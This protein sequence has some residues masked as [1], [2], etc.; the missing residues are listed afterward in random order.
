MTA[1]KIYILTIMLCAVGQPQCVMPQAI[2]EHRT[3]YD[4]VK[5]VKFYGSDG[6]KLMLN[7][8]FIWK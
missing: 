3:H 8:S 5:K 7:Y 6:N 4:C 2:S 1:A